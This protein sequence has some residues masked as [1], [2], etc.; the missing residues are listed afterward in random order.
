MSYKKEFEEALDEWL[1]ASEGL[2]DSVHRDVLLFKL[3]EVTKA[4]NKIISLLLQR[5]AFR[6]NTEI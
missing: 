3:L 1:K 2:G 6:L 5:E 4:Q